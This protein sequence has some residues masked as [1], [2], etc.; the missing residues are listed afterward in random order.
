MQVHRG[1]PLPPS[2]QQVASTQT[3]SL[4]LPVR[5]SGPAPANASEVVGSAINRPQ[6]T[7]ARQRGLQS[8]QGSEFSQLQTR[9]HLQLDYTESIRSTSSADL[10]YQYEEHYDTQNYERYAKIRI[11]GQGSPC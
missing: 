8:G 10:S 6:S 3:E 7:R 11:Y 4:K 1:S 9:R 2:P 5:E